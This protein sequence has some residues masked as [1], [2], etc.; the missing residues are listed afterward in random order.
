MC[1]RTSYGPPSY[2]YV[3]LHPY[4]WSKRLSVVEFAANN[5]NNVSTKLHTNLFEYRGESIIAREL[6]GLPYV[7]LK[8]SCGGSY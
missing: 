8:S 1:W 4:T 3:E 6:I 2:N 7:N 5:A